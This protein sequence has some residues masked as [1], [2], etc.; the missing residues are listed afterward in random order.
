MESTNEE[1]VPK[2]WKN[3]GVYNTYEEA[4]SYKAGFLAE[5]NESGALAKIRRCG[6]NGTRFKVK[7]WHPA[8]VSPKKK[9]KNK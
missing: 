4:S 2:Q 8:P 7:F 5:Y 9:R 1:A 6:E 3:L